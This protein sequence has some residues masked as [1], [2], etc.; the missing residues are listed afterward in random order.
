M[1]RQPERIAHF[2]GPSPANEIK[3]VSAASGVNFVS[4]DGVSRVRQMHPDLVR[5]ASERNRAKG[6]KAAMPGRFRAV[7]HF[8]TCDGAHA[9]R[10]NRAFKVNVGTHDFPATHNR[11][12]NDCRLPLRPA[13]NKSEVFLADAPFGHR[14]ASVSRCRGGFCYENDSACLPVEAVDEGYLAPIRELKAKK[15]PKTIP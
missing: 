5:S 13:E 11:S 2:G 10:M 15:I 1:A 12:V 6:G 7:E 4:Q 9:G 3:I 14:N 8:E